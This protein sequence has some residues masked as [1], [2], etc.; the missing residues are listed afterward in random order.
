MNDFE[1]PLSRRGAAITRFLTF[2]FEKRQEMYDWL[3]TAKTFNELPQWV[4]TAL[5]EAERK[6][7]ESEQ[8]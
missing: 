5:V 1:E 4:Q 6:L 3:N 8:L 7:D 2:D